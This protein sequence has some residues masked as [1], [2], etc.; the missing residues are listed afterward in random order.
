M[1]IEIITAMVTNEVSTEIKVS[2]KVTA[3]N[4]LAKYRSKRLRLDYYP[5]EDVIKCSRRLNIDPPCRLNIDPGRVAT[6]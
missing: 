6:F 5:A 1:N 2:N 4:R 3:R